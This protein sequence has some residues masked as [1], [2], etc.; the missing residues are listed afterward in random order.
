M[1][2]A[3]SFLDALKLAADK[4]ARAEDDFRRQTAERAKALERE[5]AFAYRRLNF[6]RAIAE[7]VAAAESEEIAVAAALAVVRM[8]L[9]W[10]SDSEARAAVL[11]RF[12]PVA[13]QVFS[14]LAPADEEEG[15]PPAEPADA[16]A[17][18]AAF[19]AWYRE[20][21]PNPFWLL[22]EHYMPETPVVDF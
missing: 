10:S 4:A 6:M 22:F 9:G 17:A 16:A 15:E 11:A 7:A 21:H 5:R 8:K 13:Q 18:L 14:A 19:E 1:T 20:T 3:P 2:P 12:A